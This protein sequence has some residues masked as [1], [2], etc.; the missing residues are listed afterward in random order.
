MNKE[1]YNKLTESAKTAFSDILTEYEDRILHEAYSIAAQN[2]PE[3]VEISLSDILSA[4]K[5]VLS[6]SKSGVVSNLVSSSAEYRKQ[7]YLF[8]I[9]STFILYI[10]GVLIYYLVVRYKIDFQKDFGLTVATTSAVLA[11]YMAILM[12]AFKLRKKVVDSKKYETETLDKVFLNSWDKIAYFGR[13]LHGNLSSQL[14]GDKYSEEDKEKFKDVRTYVDLINISLDSGLQERFKDVLRIRNILVHGDSESV[15]REEKEEAISSAN[16]IV[17]ILKRK[18]INDIPFASESTLE[19]Y[20][21]ND[22]HIFIDEFDKASDSQ[23][24]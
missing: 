21:K 18:V 1:V 17:A 11:T 23:K 16:L 22:Y 14:I 2:Q 15:T 20:Y 9:T 13:L 19:N 6:Q 10:V 7:F 8:M 4:R 12:Q 24:E 5:K 3:V